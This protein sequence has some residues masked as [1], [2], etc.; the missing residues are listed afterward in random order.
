MMG[1][2]IQDVS[3]LTGLRSHGVRTDCFV[4]QKTPSFTYPESAQLAYSIFLNCFAG[5]EGNEV[6]EEEHVALLIY[7]LNK[8]I[9]CVSSNRIAKEFTDIAKALASGQKLALAP[10]ILAHL[11]HGMQELLTNKFV[12]APG[13][14]WII[15]LWLW[16]Y[17]P[18]FAPK[19]NKKPA[20]AC[21]G[22]HYVGQALQQHAFDFCFNYFYC[23][24]TTLGKGYMPFERDTIPLWLKNPAREARE[25]FDEHK[26]VWASFLI[27]RDLLYGMGVLR[28]TISVV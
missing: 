28:L 26:E 6:T 19:M 16:S 3:F 14:L 4:S 25:D 1:I 27:S 17:F 18:T 8:C 5:E 20:Q 9:F 15:T 12:F 21:Y 22:R 11:Y 24:L 10:L 13:P 2:T 23:E 7:W